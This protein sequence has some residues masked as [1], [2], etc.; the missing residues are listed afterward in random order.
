ML[1]AA[2]SST[3]PLFGDDL[4]VH[5]SLLHSSVCALGKQFMSPPNVLHCT[6]RFIQPYIG[7]NRHSLKNLPHHT[8]IKREWMGYNTE[9]YSPST[10]SSP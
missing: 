10:S 2:A 8:V 1:T 5:W 6:V 3:A 9:L 4:L 7:L